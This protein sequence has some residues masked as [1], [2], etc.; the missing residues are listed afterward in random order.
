MTQDAILGSRVFVDWANKTSMRSVHTPFGQLVLH[1]DDEPV[2]DAALQAELKGLGLLYDI[3]RLSDSWVV[4]PGKRR[5][6]IE[7]IDFG[8]RILIDPLRTVLNRLMNDDNHLVMKMD[9]DWACVLASG[10]AMEC[11]IVDGLVSVVLLGTA[12]WP[13]KHTPSTLQEKAKAARVQDRL[14][15]RGKSIDAYA[16]PLSYEEIIAFHEMSDHLQTQASRERLKE[17]GAYARRLYVCR[18]HDQQSVQQHVQ[19]LMEGLEADEIEAYCNEPEVA[20]DA[21]FLMPQMAR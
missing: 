14:D 4:F 12:G 18:G 21:M 2:E 9:G 20:A 10:Q 16:I 11:A 3:V 15:E 17:I 6:Y 13:D 1:D 19:L 5:D 8:P 7:S